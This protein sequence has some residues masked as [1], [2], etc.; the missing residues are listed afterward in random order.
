VK[1][2]G[3]AGDALADDARAL[4]DE[5]AHGARQVRGK[6]EGRQGDMGTRGQGERGQ[7]NLRYLEHIFLPNRQYRKCIGH[8]RRGLAIQLNYMM[9]KKGCQLC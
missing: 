4:V 6:R 1:R 9:A 2:A 8:Q 7:G 3:G 5:D